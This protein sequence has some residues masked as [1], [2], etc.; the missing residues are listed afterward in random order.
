MRDSRG[1]AA[2]FPYNF[3]NKKAR[4]LK[5]DQFLFKYKAGENFN[6]PQYDLPDLR[7]RQTYIKYFED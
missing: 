5:N 6:S 7:G 2:P 1:G 3:N 4:P